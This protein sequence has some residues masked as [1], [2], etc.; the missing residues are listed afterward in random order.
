MKTFSERNPL[1]IGAIGLGIT[2]AVMLIS[3]N[4]DKLPFFN[5]GKSY[6]AYF[7]EAGGLIPGNAV[8]VSGLR[9]GQVS[10]VELDG[11]RVLVKFH[12]AGNVRLGDRTEAAIKLKTLL[13]NKVLEVTPRGDGKLTG[14]IP[15]DRTRPAYQL[16]DALGDLT[17]TIS[18]LNTDQLSNSLAVLADTFSDT[19]PDLKAAVQGLARFSQTLDER[20][21]QLRNL[22][23]NA[24]KAT[25]VLAER[26]DEVVKLIANTNALLVQLKSQSSALDQIS[27]N[28][29]AAAQQVRGFIAENRNTLKPALDKLNEVLAIVDNRKERVQKALTG[30]NSFSLRLGETVSSTPFYKAYVANL[31]P[32]QFVQPFIDA[33][34]SD[35]GLDPNVLLPSQLTDPEVGQPGTPPLPMPYPRTGQGGEPRMTIP[36]AITGNPSDHPC[37]LPGVALPGPGCYPYREPPPAPPPGGPPPGPPALPSPQPDQGGGQ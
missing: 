31:L 23:S 9:V 15:L 25:K 17:T 2:A 29:S 1:R 10:G 19:P 32:G 5:T 14:P 20:D 28:L 33:A 16:P 22:L 34:F 27:N 12:V 4:Y 35:L 30:L 36:D 21:T 6:S 11:P 18:G 8:Q 24:N 7:A 26:S 13:G 3:L 37:G